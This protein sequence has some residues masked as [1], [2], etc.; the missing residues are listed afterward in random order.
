M[1]GKEIFRVPAYDRDFGPNGIVVHA[2]SS[3]DL[4]SVFRIDIQTGTVTLVGPLDRE[5][6]SVYRLNITAYDL[7]TSHLSSS[8]SVSVYVVDVNDNRPEFAMDTS[9]LFISEDTE[10]GSSVAQFIAI[11]EDEGENA[12]IS[13]ELVTRTEHFRIH[14]VSGTL[15]VISKLDREKIEE[16]NLHILLS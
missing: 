12:E 7:G 13:Y 10:I 3:G 11:D 6:T 8:K 9:S 15:Y 1:I 2:I 14:S 4:D 16:F 5:R